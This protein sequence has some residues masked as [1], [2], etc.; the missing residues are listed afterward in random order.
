MMLVEYWQLYPTDKSPFAQLDRF[1][2]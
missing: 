1:I 2:V